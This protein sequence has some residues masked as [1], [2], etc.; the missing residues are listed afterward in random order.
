MKSQGELIDDI[1]FQLNELKDKTILKKLGSKGS[2]WLKVSIPLVEIGN[3]NLTLLENYRLLRIINKKETVEI[4]NL[5]G[6]TY[7]IVSFDYILEINPIFDDFLKELEIKRNNLFLPIEGRFIDIKELFIKYGLIKNL[8][9]ISTNE[10]VSIIKDKERDFYSYRKEIGILFKP[11]IMCID[12]RYKKILVFSK[13]ETL[14]KT[15]DITEELLKRN[16]FKL[17]ELLSKFE[18]N[19]VLTPK[20][21]RIILDSIPT[22]KGINREK[23]YKRSEHDN[24]RDFINYEKEIQRIF[25]FRVIEPGDVKGNWKV[26]VKVIKINK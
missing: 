16:G 23:G 15:K 4:I 21:K 9:S 6:Q 2:I 8:N 24:Q 12:H 11:P 22:E 20:D 25:G 18:I 17:L 19:E 7:N 13:S 3:I 5:S 10:T 1:Y 26:V 14:D